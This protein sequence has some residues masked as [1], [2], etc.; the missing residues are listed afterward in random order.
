M[1]LPK[2]FM[3]KIFPGV[4]DDSWVSDR[5]RAWQTAVAAFGILALE[6]AVIRWSAGQIRVFAYFNNLVLISAFLGVGLGAVL[7]RKIGGLIHLVLPVLLCLSIPLAFS[8][9]LGLVHMH[10]PDSVVFLWS[11]LPR[12]T[13]LGYARNIAIF[14]SLFG[15][16]AV[17]FTCCGAALGT[18]FAVQQPLRAYTWDLLGALAG[19]V[20]FTMLTYFNA[21][22]PVWLF[23]GGLPFLILSRSLTSLCALI[24]VVLLGVYSVGDAVYSPY[25]RID[26]HRSGGYFDIDVNRSYH[27]NIY[28]LSDAVMNSENL[29]PQD[30]Q[31]RI[32]L[33]R[34]YDLPY[35]INAARSSALIV[36]SGTGNDVQAALRNGYGSVY[37]IDIDARLVDLGKAIHPEQPYASPKVRTVI[38][39]ARAFF[40]QYAGEPFDV[41]SYGL[42]DSHAMFSSMSSL[43]LDNY[44]Y[45]V[46]GI[47]AAWQ[48]VAPHGHL[49]INFSCY[50]G[51]WLA[52]RLYWTIYEATGIK[53]I[54]VDSGMNYG[55]NFLVATDMNRLDATRIDQHPRLLQEAVATSI[56]TTT[57]DWPFLYIRPG[58]FPWG[59]V[60]TLGAVI[61]ITLCAV[62][63]TFGVQELK[64]KFE[65]ALFFLGAA[66]MLL[67]TRGITSL[68]LVFGSTWVV[69]AAIFFGILLVALVANLLVARSCSARFLHTRLWFSLL[70]VSLI[71]LWGFDNAW[72]NQFPLLIRG[73]VGGVVNVLPVAFAGVIFSTLFSR[74]KY[75]EAALG[76]NLLGAVIGGCAEYLSMW[77][78]LRSLVV[79]ATVFYALA[80]L[81]VRQGEEKRTHGMATDP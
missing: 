33:R 30:M 11:G 1:T 35:T 15:L 9:A 20:A 69:N 26:V 24:G 14:L 58:L 21:P 31:W 32:S 10:F 60:M 54:A 43:R 72:L 68:S 50:A 53:P 67:E 56:N 27:Q 48:H 16:T 42:L 49:S 18:L 81:F 7:G 2:Q 36:G 22:P 45:T 65:P 6:L 66:F 74:S 79:L 34:A 3:G 59:Y 63:L 40:E 25:N 41:V 73:T 8:E 4:Y 77:L 44:V 13:L 19:V 28:D 62:P 39:D 46:E 12:F 47:R 80:L 55:V 5:R 64:H 37:A 23:L 57:D 29:P 61:V 70:F 75:P 76:S 17:V 52:E 78:G 51:L 38:N 71:V